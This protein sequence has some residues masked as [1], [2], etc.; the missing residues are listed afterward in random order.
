M[1]SSI[2]SD[3]ERSFSGSKWSLWW[4]IEWWNPT[5]VE[6]CPFGTSSGIYLEGI[7]KQSSEKI[8]ILNFYAPYKYRESFWQPILDYG[9]LSEE[10][11]IVGGYLNFTL[12]AREVWGNLARSDPLADLFSN[13]IPTSSLVD[14]HPTQMDP[15]WRNG[16]AG[17]TSIS[18]ILDRFLLDE[19]LLGSHSKIRSWIINSTISDHNPIFLQFEK[20]SHKVS[21][22]FKFN[23]T[24]IYDLRFSSLIKNTWYS[25]EN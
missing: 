2:S 15:T 20:S 6:L 10:G 4:I 3:V 16:R 14:I 11:I 7:F 5:Y 19:T 12:S 13:I 18:K 21:P 25:V 9:L 17:T 23:N 8:K 1:F 22:P 24:W